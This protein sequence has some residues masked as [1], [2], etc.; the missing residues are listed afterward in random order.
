MLERFLKLKGYQVLTADNGLSALE[1]VRDSSPGLVILD[2]EM[3]KMG[4]LEFLQVARMSRPNLP[5]IV[6]SGSGEAETLERVLTLGASR[7]IAKPPD[8][9]DLLKSVELGLAG[10]ALGPSA[11]RFVDKKEGTAIDSC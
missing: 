10:G 1:A 9:N 11:C 7:Y 6:L 3:P 5:V 2:L 4:G 8:L